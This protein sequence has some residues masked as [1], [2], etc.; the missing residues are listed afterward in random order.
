MNIERMISTVEVHT[1]GEPF[2]IVERRAW[3]E[4]N[5]DKVREVRETLIYE[6]RGMRTCVPDI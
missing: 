1:G 6:P 4:E 2:R 5:L 3:V